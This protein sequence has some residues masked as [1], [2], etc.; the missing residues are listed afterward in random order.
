M[1]GVTVALFIQASGV[2]GKEGPS[3]IFGFKIGAGGGGGGDMGRH[4]LYLPQRSMQHG[5]MLLLWHKMKRIVSL[6]GYCS[7]VSDV[8][9]FCFLSAKRRSVPDSQ[10]RLVHRTTSIPILGAW[11]HLVYLLW[12]QRPSLARVYVCMF[13]RLY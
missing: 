5:A 7:A 1:V 6:Y 3:N 2:A 12:S 4:K 9:S 11:A 10:K 13:G 8:V